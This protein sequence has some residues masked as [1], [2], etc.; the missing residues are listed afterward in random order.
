MTCRFDPPSVERGGVEPRLDVASH[1]ETMGDNDMANPKTTQIGVRLED[2]L[3]ARIDAYAARVAAEL[4]G[5][6][7][8]R[9]DAIRVLVTKGLAASDERRPKE[10]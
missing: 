7:F 5:V 3:V 10:P 8:G 9:S 1:W 4:P 6:R 2:D